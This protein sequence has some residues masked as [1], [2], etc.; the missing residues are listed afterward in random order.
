MSGVDTKPGNLEDGFW[1]RYIGGFAPNIQLLVPT[2]SPLEIPRFRVHPWRVSSLFHSRGG[3]K[4]PSEDFKNSVL[5]P[6]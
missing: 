6:L 4:Q 1:E 5:R 2:E 3:Q